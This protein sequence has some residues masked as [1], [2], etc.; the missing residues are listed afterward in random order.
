M[1]TSLFVCLLL[2]G[3]AFGIMAQTR[4]DLIY[5]VDQTSFAANVDEIGEAEIMY[6]LPTDAL[7]QRPQ[8]IAKAQVWK[9][10]FAN[11]D[12]EEL[13]QP[14]AKAPV[15]ATNDRIVQKNGTVLEGNVVKVGERTVEYRR[16]GA[17]SGPVYEIEIAK[18]NRIEYANGEVEKFVKTLAV[19]PTSSSSKPTAAAKPK[20]EKAKTA[21]KPATS[22]PKKEVAQRAPRVKPTRTKAPATDREFFSLTAGGDAAYVLGAKEWTDEKR[23]IGMGIGAG[24][25]VSASLHITR[26]LAITA[27]GGLLQ[28]EIE[29]NFKDSLSSNLLMRRNNVIKMIPINAGLKIYPAKGFYIAPQVSYTLYQ[30]TGS[31]FDPKTE[32]TTEFFGYKGNKLGYRGEI[33]YEH[34]GKGFRWQLGVYY[35]TLL[36]KDLNEFKKIDPMSFVGARLAIG[37]G[38]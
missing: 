32:T 14:Q 20:S 15:V 22:K 10:V 11:G 6:F 7:K 12:V 8:R 35:S 29:R 38:L 28:W 26:W 3:H 21:A 2:V 18:L 24:A 36:I 30:E 31:D 27:N 5:K 16:V 1:R 23:G 19:K 9:I 17:T 37:F 33:G 34:R 4:N 13:N 25:S